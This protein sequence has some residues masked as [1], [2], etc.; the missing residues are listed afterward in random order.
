MGQAKPKLS[1][2]ELFE[3]RGGGE[4]VTEKIPSPYHVLEL[5]KR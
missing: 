1:P 5:D 3:K 4:G 2:T